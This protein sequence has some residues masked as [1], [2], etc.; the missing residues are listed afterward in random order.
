MKRARAKE[1]LILHPPENSLVGRFCLNAT[2]DVSN[3]VSFVSSK[4]TVAFMKVVHTHL[5][6]ET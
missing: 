2:V 6:V 1:I 4:V 5:T 3:Y